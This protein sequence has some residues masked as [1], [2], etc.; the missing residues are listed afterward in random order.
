MSFK[1]NC[2]V[3]AK[4]PYFVDVYENRGGFKARLTNRGCLMDGHVVKSVTFDL[5]SQ[6]F[7]SVTWELK[8]TVLR[9]VDFVLV[10]TASMPERKSVNAF[11]M[12]F[13]WF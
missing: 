9:E 4:N 1:E 11:T 6:L 8:V 2:V 10:S 5:F 12:I 7:R 3:I 13:H